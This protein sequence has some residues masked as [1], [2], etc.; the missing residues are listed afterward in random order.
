MGLFIELREALASSECKEAYR[1]SLVANAHRADNGP[2]SA[3]ALALPC[4]EDLDAAQLERI[5]LPSAPTSFSLELAFVPLM[6]LDLV[7]Y[8]TALTAR[9]N[10]EKSGSSA[11]TETQSS[12]T[13][14]TIK[15]KY[16]QTSIRP[17]ALKS[18]LFGCHGSRPIAT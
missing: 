17:T 4:Q 14:L 2:W 7:A 1:G 6:S 3:L 16:G 11:R 5:Y 15:L 13:Q 18:Q 9:L 8:G 12:P 10:P